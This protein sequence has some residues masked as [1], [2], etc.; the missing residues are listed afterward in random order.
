MTPAV[1]TELAGEIVQVTAASER[2]VCATLTW[3]RTSVRYA[4]K[5]ASDEA[6]RATLRKLAAANPR[7][8]YR[9]LQVMLRRESIRL[10]RGTVLRL[11]REE[12]LSVHRKRKVTQPKEIV[13]SQTPPPERPNQG[14]ALDFTHEQL[15]SGERFR[16]LTVVDMFTREVV[17]TQAA[18]SFKADD[19][20]AVLRSAI[21]LRDASP[22]WL[23]SDN[24]SAF[25]AELSAEFLRVKGIEHK[26]S[27]PGKPTDNPMIESF[28]SR[29][30]DELLDRT[31]FDSVADAN[32]QLSRFQHYY[33]HVRPHS[34]IRYLTP[35]EFHAR[36]LSLQSHVAR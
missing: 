29:F 12:K 25:I 1:R 34:G 15:A 3:P 36:H 28:H 16:I 30:R 11:C 17:V 6:T 27:R 32:D 9:R 33:N 4:R 22:T 21:A 13:R 23:R 7:F 20:R 24:G 10:S 18:A 8:G 31:L 5:R 2:R 26:R 14:W 19:V 35:A